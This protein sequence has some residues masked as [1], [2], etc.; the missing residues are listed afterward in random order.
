[1]LK[2]RAR[3]R[4]SHSTAVTPPA[5]DTSSARLPRLSSPAFGVL[6]YALVLWQMAQMHEQVQQTE[7]MAAQHV[8]NFQAAATCVLMLLL[9]AHR[10]LEPRPPMPGGLSD[11]MLS[12][13]DGR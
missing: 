7:R 11:A 10:P 8:A 13:T 3:P 6:I 9:T 5:L 1:M 2:G 12:D 4:S